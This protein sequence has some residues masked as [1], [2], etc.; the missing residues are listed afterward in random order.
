VEHKEPLLPFTSL[1]EYFRRFLQAS[2]MNRAGVPVSVDIKAVFLAR[3]IDLR[4]CQGSWLDQ[5]DG[6]LLSGEVGCRFISVSDSKVIDS[7]GG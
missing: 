1:S 2:P 6:R 3:D 5:E 7:V 4:R